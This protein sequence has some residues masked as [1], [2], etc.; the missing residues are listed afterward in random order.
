MRGLFSYNKENVMKKV[1]YGFIIAVAVLAAGC[2][3]TTDPGTTPG[4]ENT[5]DGTFVAVTGI[6]LW[7]NSRIKNTTIDLNALAVVSP[8]DATVQTIAWFVTD[9]GTTGVA[10]GAVVGGIVTPSAAGTLTLSATVANGKTN[11][12]EDFIEEGLT[13]TVTEEFVAVTDITW[14][15]PTGKKAGGEFQISGFTVEPA[16]ATHSVIVWSVAEGSA[17]SATVS[18][19]SV[20]NTVE[21][22]LTLTAT[23][24]NGSAEGT[25]YTKTF[26][27]T[28]AAAGE[29]EGVPAG[30]IEVDSAATLAKI[31][32]PDETDYPLN[33]KYFQTADFSI[34]N[35]WT[36]V[37]T[38]AA[39]FTGTYDGDGKTITPTI[40]TSGVSSYMSIFG[41]A[42]EATFKN[43]KTGAT[44]SISVTGNLSGAAGI[45][46]DARNNTTF[47][48][49]SNAA[50]VT[51]GY[52]AAGICDTLYNSSVIGCSNTGSITGGEAGGINHFMRVSVV[53]NCFNGGE[54]KA[55]TTQVTPTAGGICAN[56]QQDT[57]I[58]ACYSTGKVTSK[59]AGMYQTDIGGIAGR[60]G[61]SGGQEGVKI[62]AC[63][64]TGEVS[65]D[66]DLGE[67]EFGY[68]ALGGIV[69][70][71]WGG[72]ITITA[73]YSTGTPEYKGVSTVD[74][75]DNDLYQAICVGGI[76]G[77]CG[78]EKDNYSAPTFT[79]CYWVAVNGIMG[80]GG[81]DPE[82]SDPYPE[83]TDPSDDYT[84]KFGDTSW[85]SY[86]GNWG[87]EYWKSFSSGVYPKLAWEEE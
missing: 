15:A 70:W 53:Q 10:A 80:I 2:E 41:Y 87:S 47:T 31:G 8:A 65:T 38:S 19:T 75:N 76:A 33:G 13:I 18:G 79:G 86:S 5:G 51:G 49:C 27:V 85:P 71:T 48:N 64:N 6:T 39:K 62:I 17:V 7:E 74:K 46:Y 66:I 59:G 12:T 56:P 23:I 60:V 45:A 78:V 26:T 69:G 52:S 20:T 25:A 21:G 54:I 57:Q 82:A 77:F 63:Y 30:W 68:V 42:E 73:C 36:P 3:Q 72:T 61:A 81:I 55:E 43:I 58:I 44:G 22:T 16:N 40:S 67:E 29:E 11:G 35:P 84:T 14:A 34:S 32:N 28:I 50:T 83:E 37:G 24:A 1:I 4:N 9:A